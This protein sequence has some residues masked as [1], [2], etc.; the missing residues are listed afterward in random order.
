M[1][2]E[3]GCTGDVDGGCV[4]RYVPSPAMIPTPLLLPV[5]A[6][7]AMLLLIRTCSRVLYCCRRWCRYEPLPFAWRCM[8]ACCFIATFHT[9]LPCRNAWLAVVHSRRQ[10]RA[11]RWR[12]CRCVAVLRNVCVRIVC[13]PPPPACPYSCASRAASREL[14]TNVQAGSGVAGASPPPAM[15]LLHRLTF[16]P[17]LLQERELG[18]VQR[19]P[20]G[21]DG[22]R[23]DGGGGAGAWW[24]V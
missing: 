16:S 15:F 23:L 10:K 20:G 22:G 24:V 21:L 13:S 18:A 3:V 9:L 12:R 4:A 6:V 5:G 11:L 2:V 19:R 8:C 14:S 17:L 7:Y 1:L